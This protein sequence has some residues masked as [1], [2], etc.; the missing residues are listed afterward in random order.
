MDALYLAK[1]P[2]RFAGEVPPYINR[3]MIDVHETKNL[4]IRGAVETM[5]C[6]LLRHRSVGYGFFGG[7]SNK[8]DDCRADAEVFVARVLLDHSTDPCFAR[9]DFA[10]RLRFQLENCSHE[11]WEDYGNPDQDWNWGRAQTDF[12]VFGLRHIRMLF[13]NAVPYS[14]SEF[15]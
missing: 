15:D 2:D 1:L 3:A 9:S 5:A 4:D 6:E 12:A 14:Q 11:I 10:R 8:I 7:R 13:D